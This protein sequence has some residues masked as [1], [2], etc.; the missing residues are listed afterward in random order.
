MDFLDLATDFL[1]RDEKFLVGLS[2]FRPN[3]FTP[4][5]TKTHE[6]EAVLLYN[7]NNSILPIDV[8]LKMHSCR[9][10]TIHLKNG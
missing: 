1:L 9:E 6:K 8:T 4:S 3:I 5:M 2:K 10:C 7:F